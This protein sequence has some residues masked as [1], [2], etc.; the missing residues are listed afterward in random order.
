MES[1][2]GQE[3]REGI[4]E[5]ADRQ[6]KRSGRTSSPPPPLPAFPPRIALPSALPMPRTVRMPAELGWCRSCAVAP[7]LQLVLAQLAPMLV[8]SGGH[9]YVVPWVT[10]ASQNLKIIGGDV[11]TSPP[12]T[13]LSAQPWA[14]TRV[15]RLQKLDLG[16]FKAK[17]SSMG[18][19][20]LCKLTQQKAPLCSVGFAP[21]EELQL[22]WIWR[23]VLSQLRCSTQIV[24][25]FLSWSQYLLNKK[26]VLHQVL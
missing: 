17:C 20:T 13:S 19:Q 21:K 16:I 25:L 24:L 18:I 1:C 2:Y 12:I 26:E 3:Y 4:K 7:M 5:S 23:C 22:K 6:K 11:T 9:K 8:T 10:W 14:R 15:M